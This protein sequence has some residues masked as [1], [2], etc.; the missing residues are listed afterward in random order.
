MTELDEYATKY[1]CAKIERRGDG[2]LHVRLHTDDGPFQWGLG[3]QGELV[4]LFTDIGAG[5]WLRYF[6]GTLEVAGAIGLMLPFLCGLASL[7][8]LTMRVVC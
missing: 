8:L 7:G 1:S 3:P 5:Q 2:I 4:R 6:T